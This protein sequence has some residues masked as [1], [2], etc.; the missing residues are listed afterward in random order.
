M[1]IDRVNNWAALVVLI[2]VIVMPLAALGAFISDWYPVAGWIL[3]AP[4]FAFAAILLI[5]ALAFI[6]R[7]AWR[8]AWK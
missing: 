7:E 5:G 8:E 4:F 2:M 3:L 1:I 6:F